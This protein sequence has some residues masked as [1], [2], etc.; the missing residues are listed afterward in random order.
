MLMRGL[1]WAERF[2]NLLR[3]FGA[4]DVSVWDGALKLRML[5]L[6]RLL[7]HL[8]AHVSHHV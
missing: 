1:S 2:E 8:H 6:A 5:L 4:Q 7:R 3:F